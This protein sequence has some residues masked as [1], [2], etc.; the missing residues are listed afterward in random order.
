MTS[1]DEKKK[2]LHNS[3]SEVLD[4]RVIA[5][6][7]DPGLDEDYHFDILS[8]YVVVMLESTFLVPTVD[9]WV[10]MFAI[11]RRQSHLWIQTAGGISSSPATQQRSDAKG[12]V[13]VGLA[14]SFSTKGIPRMNQSY[15]LGEQ[16]KIRRL[17]TALTSATYP[18]FFQSDFTTFDNTNGF[19]NSWHTDGVTLPYINNDPTK[20]QYLR[21]KTLTSTATQGTY[22]FNLNK[23]QYEAFT[24]ALSVSNSIMSSVMTQI[25]SNTWYNGTPVYQANGGYVFGSKASV[26]LGACSFED[27]NLNNK[28]RLATN[29]CIPLVVATPT[30]F[31]TPKQ[32][33]VGT[34]A[35]TP[36]YSPIAR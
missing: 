31:P 9:R 4:A 14:G 29:E 21:T 6:Y 30:A 10:G 26:N 24:L 25:F 32:R 11:V 17:P 7:G 1:L 20:T 16:I 33:A 18:A 22:Y 23:I 35:Y 27:I 19:Y 5:N 13:S 28:M 34:I 15:Q 36:T 3:Q 2:T 8:R 12:N